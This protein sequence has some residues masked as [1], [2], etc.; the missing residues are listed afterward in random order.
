MLTTVSRV[1]VLSLD[2]ESEQSELLDD[3][4][5]DVLTGGGGGAFTLL[6]SLTGVEHFTGAERLCEA[7]SS[8]D[9]SV[10]DVN[11]FL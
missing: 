3:D 1:L 5:D 7:A 2:S 11:I 10:E 9:E 6:T 4:V 8:S